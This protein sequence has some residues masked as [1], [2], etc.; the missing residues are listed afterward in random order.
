M[1]RK[2]FDLVKENMS[3]G[4]GNNCEYKDAKECPACDDCD[5]CEKCLSPDC[6][7]TAMF[8]AYK[9]IGRDDR[10]LREF[11]RGTVIPC[12]RQMYID[13]LVKPTKAD[14]EEAEQ[15]LRENYS[16]ILAY[17]EGGE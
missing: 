10:Y 8:W 13:S 15:E 16:D 1:R 7:L 6:I 4:D 2:F 3:Y 11:A 14:V 12:L 9:E 5:C 17:A